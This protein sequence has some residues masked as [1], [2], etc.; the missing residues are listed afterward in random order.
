MLTIRKLQA[1][2]GD[3]R[4][5]MAAAEYATTENGQ[6]AKTVWLGDQA[7]L[8]RLGLV[9][10]THV[11]AE[12]LAAA[13][14]GQHVVTGEQVRRPGTR[15]ATDA[16]G[17]PLVDENG[18]RIKEPVV[19]SFDLTFS[20]PKS[21]SVAWA[22]ADPV[23][24]ADLEQA[25]VTAANAA[26]EH[27]TSTRRV[28]SNASTAEA[29]AAAAALHRFARTAKG[30]DVPAPQLHVHT[31]L[32][33]V[34]AAGESRLRTPAAAA[35]FKDFAM[36]EAGAVG[37][38][39]L[40]QELERLGFRIVVRTG[41]NGR[42]FEIEGIDLDLC[43][44]MSGRSRDVA[45]QVAAWE[46][47]EGG[48]LSGLQASRAA[49]ATAADK[50]VLP[51]EE[52]WAAYRAMGEAFGVDHETI[53]GL[54]SDLLAEHDG[55]ALRVQLRETLLA[56]M[57]EIGPTA[58]MGEL[59]SIAFE[60]DAAGLSVAEVEGVLASM[61][62][63][64][65]LISLEGWRV[66]TRDIREKELFVRDVAVA[67]AQSGRP[68]LSEEA[69]AHGIAVAEASLKGH[70]LDDEQLA[71]VRKLTSGADWTILTG[72]A[73][74]GKGPVLE[75]V[76]HAHMY[77]GW[78]VIACALDGATTQR[79]G[80]QIAA[81]ALTIEQLRYRVKKRR[82][83]LDQ[84]TLI[85]TDEA[86]KN[87]LTD[88]GFVAGLV[89]DDDNDLRVLGVGDVGQIGAIE[90]PGML[91]VMIADERIPTAE[92]TEVR[93]HRDPKDKSKTHPWLVKYQ[94]ALHAGFP[95][96]AIGLLR[97]HGAIELMDTRE[98]AMVALVER[99]EQ[100]RYDH[101]IEVQD[102]VLIVH[103]SNEDVDA[104][105]ELAQALRLR[106]NEIGGDSVAAVDRGYR[107]HAGEVV[108]L[109]E[110]AYEP[111]G[112]TED[113]LGPERIENGTMGLVTRVDAASERVWVEFETP[114][115]DSREEVVD[116]RELRRKHA[117]KKD[118]DRVAALRLA[119]AGHPFPMQGA[120]FDYIGSLWGHWSQRN[121]ET[122]S[123]D[124]RAKLY[125]DVWGDRESF[126]LEGDDDDRYERFAKRIE[127]RFHKLASITYEETGDIAVA[128]S[129][130]QRELAPLLAAVHAVGERARAVAAEERARAAAAERA[131]ERERA[132][133]ARHLGAGR[134][135][136]RR[137][138]T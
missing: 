90:L 118:G 34:M 133:M 100:R 117:K 113:A 88:W 122:Y 77:E 32:L 78:E 31:E 64:G 114:D 137:R 16:D 53:A 54:R 108:M 57:W 58:S 61:L 41:K 14:R 29:F 96:E 27:V 23:L 129:R 99:W 132:A 127:K 94:E 120:T 126:G 119:Y 62:A 98:E 49:A 73:G 20:A 116:L 66:T 36:R 60:H 11:S 131:A 111:P 24:R 121:E 80:H 35:L 97:E 10:G 72:L 93:R 76:A 75:A 74:T 84:R 106:A 7:A 52:I 70:T 79:L 130:A 107:I 6:P 21:V 89:D 125:L 1:K 22:L 12:D 112:E 40:A 82:I 69:V 115:G 124:T 33:G 44:L 13:L 56:R 83:A 42:Y 65:D 71:A 103:G 28:V 101:G 17:N 5:A 135:D 68:R 59:R 46:A 45:A 109:R 51:E 43:E 18:E 48:K 123:G 3:R 15:R 8:D 25:M 136:R 92:L 30:E 91:D 138:G 81:S 87:G 38:A 63:K 128:R 19:N 105:N 26:V 85:L 67:A 9:R 134:G 47:R 102:A 50:E 110:A 39:V 37:R 4:G 2:P 104:V 55:D 95:Q 86:S